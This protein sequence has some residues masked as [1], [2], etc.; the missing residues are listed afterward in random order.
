MK[1]TTVNKNISNKTTTTLSHFWRDATNT[2]RTANT[3]MNKNVLLILTP[4]ENRKLYELSF[5]NL[6]FKDKKKLN[7][8]AEI[9]N[10]CLISIYNGETGY[11]FTKDQ[12]REV[13]KILPRVEIKRDVICDCYSCWK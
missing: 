6:N 7:Y 2:W 4:I 13:K 1:E 11:V 8:S 3:G 5:D 9:I 10:D 12:L